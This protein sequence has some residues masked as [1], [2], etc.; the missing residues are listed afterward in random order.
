MRLTRAGIALII[1]LLIVCPLGAGISYAALTGS[2]VGP[3]SFGKRATATPTTRSS[4]ATNTPVAGGPT[5]F[6]PTAT[7]A[8]SAGPPPSAPAAAQAP[9]GTSAAQLP[10]SPTAGPRPSAA[11]ASATAGS[12]PTATAARP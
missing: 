12:G 4:A 3:I 6:T 1:F 11:P 2:P 8:P 10:V 7:R 9:P 5:V